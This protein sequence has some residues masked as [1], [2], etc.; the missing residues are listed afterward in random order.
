VGHFREKLFGIAIA[1]AVFLPDPAGAKM[2]PAPAEITNWGPENAGFSMAIAPLKQQYHVGEPIEL[3]VSVRYLAGQSPVFHF[4]DSG[5]WNSH[6]VF[7]VT[8]SSGGRDSILAQPCNEHTPELRNPHPGHPDFLAA[9]EVL[10]M[11]VNLL[12]YSNPDHFSTPGV[13]QVFAAERIEE[14]AS[15]IDLKANAVTL[16]IV[17]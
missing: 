14:A 6:A 17:P 3:F 2:G 13:Y 15:D 9:G 4:G 11:K 1:I 12:D 16:T 8:D 7:V 10:T 5:C